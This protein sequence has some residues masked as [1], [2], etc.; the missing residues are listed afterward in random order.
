MVLDFHD[1]NLMVF[2]LTFYALH[3]LFSINAL[4]AQWLKN[5]I[6]SSPLNARVVFIFSFHPYMFFS[7]IFSR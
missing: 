4:F 6:I 5:P 2:G 7:L 3:P 1:F